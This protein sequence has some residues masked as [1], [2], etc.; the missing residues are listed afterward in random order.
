MEV[1]LGEGFSIH[2]L[3]ADY[4]PSCYSSFFSF[5]FPLSFEVDNWIKG[6]FLLSLLVAKALVV[7]HCSRSRTYGKASTFPSFM[8][9]LA[10]GLHLHTPSMHIFSCSTLYSNSLLHSAFSISFLGIP[11]YS[12][13]FVSFYDKV[14]V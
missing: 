2:M 8:C 4:V 7:L 5:T 14:K 10:L 11:I 3:A 12:G 9:Y 1:F 6:S 13:L